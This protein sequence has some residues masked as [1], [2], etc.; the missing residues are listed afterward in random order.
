LPP[1]VIEHLAAEYRIGSTA[2]DLGRRYGVAK[3]T[4][5]RLIRQAGEPVRYPRLSLDETASVR[6]LYEAGLTQKDIAERLGRSP[7]AVWHCLRRLGLVEGNAPV[8]RL[9]VCRWPCLVRCRR[10]SGVNLEAL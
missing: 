7:S 9:R 8:R 6:T 1:E 3:T 10:K 4:I 5:L 2:A